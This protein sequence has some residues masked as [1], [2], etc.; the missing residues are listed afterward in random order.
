ME[1]KDK[2]SGKNGRGLDTIGKR[3]LVLTIAI[4]MT[5][6]FCTPTFY[7]ISF[8]DEEEYLETEQPVDEQAVEPAETPDEEVQAEEPQG[9]ASDPVL[10][11]AVTEEPA[12][13]VPADTVDEQEEPA[14]PEE[15]EPAEPAAE[16]PAVEPADEEPQDE[17][18]QDEQPADEEPAGAQPEDVQPAEEPQEPAEEEPA[19][20]PFDDTASANGV[21][22]HVTAEEGVLPEG[23]S[24]NVRKVKG[25]DVS[26]T[27]DEALDTENAKFRAVEFAFEDA[28]GNAV[29]PQDTVTV[30]LTSTAFS[31]DADLSVVDLDKAEEVTDA[32]KEEDNSVTFTADGPMTLALAEEQQPTRGGDAKAGDQPKM[33]T[34]TFDSTTDPNEPQSPDEI[35]VVNGEA[36]G[37]QLP[38]VPE[39][40][41]YVTYWVIQGTD[42]VV[43]ADTVVTKPFTAVVKQGNKITYTV[44]FVQEDGTTSTKTTDIDSGFAIRE[45]PEVTP[46]ANSVGKWVYPNTTNEFTVGTVISEDLTVNAYYE[47]DI[48]TVS[49]MVDDAE[50]SQMTTAKGASIILPTD[51]VKAGTTFKGWYTEPNGEGTRYTD[52]EGEEGETTVTSDLTLYAYFEG[53]VT[54]KFLVKDDNGNIITEKSQYFIDLTVGDEITTLPDDPFIEGK[55]FDHWEHETTHATVDVGTVVTKSFNAV[56]VFKEIDTYEL[57]VYYYY[58]NGDNEV[59]IQTQVYELIDSDFTGEEETYT[60]TAPGFTIAS[61]IPDKPTYYPSRPT[62]TVKKSDFT[63]ENGKYV[64]LENDE[65][66]KADGKY[67]VGHYL[68]NLSGEGYSLIGEFEP[69]EGVKNTEVTP[70]INSYPYADFERRDENVLIED[71][72]DQILSVYYTR[73]DFTLSYNVDGGDYIEAVTAPYGT[74]IPLPTTATRKGYTFEGWY[75][76]TEAVSG[77]FTLEENTTLDAHWTPADVNYKIVYMLENADDDGYS[78][79][80]DVT[81]QEATGTTL[82]LTKAQADSYAPSDLDLQNFT[83]KESTTEK[84]K[85][86]GSSVIVVKYS[87]NVYTLNWNG[88]RYH[89]TVDRWGNVSWNWDN[90]S[91]SG[92]V[93]A[94]Y[95]ASITEA[96]ISTFNTP[97]PDYAWALTQQNDDKIMAIDTMPGR[98]EKWGTS[99]TTLTFPNNV[100][101]VYAFDFSTTKM[102]TLNYWL[103]NYTGEGV[104]T[105]TRDGKTYGLYKDVT[106][107][108]NYLYDNADFYYI[109]G[110]D[111][112]GYE[113]QY[114]RVSYR[115]GSRDYTDADLLSV[116]TDQSTLTTLERN[117]KTISEY[118]VSYSGNTYYIKYNDEWYKLDDDGRYVYNASR[119]YGIDIDDSYILGN[120]TPDGNLILNFYYTAKTHDLTFYNYDGTLISTQKVKLNADISGYLEDNIPENPK[121]G[122]V[123]IDGTEWLGWFTD[124]EHTE[125]YTVEEGTTPKMPAGL[126]LY[127]NFSFPERTVTF[128]SQG[129]SAV[130]SQ[131][132]EYGFYASVPTDPTRANYTFQGWFTAADETGAPYDWNSPVKNDITLYAHWTQKTISYIVHYYEQGTTNSVLPDKEVSDPSFREGQEI[133]ENAPTVAGH[134]ADN[135]SVTKALSFNEEENVIIFYY[136]TIPDEIEYTVNYVLKSNPSIKVAEPKTITVP[137]STTTVLEKAVAADAAYIA[138]QTS[139]ADIIGKNYKPTET[140]K[141]LQLAK[142][143]NVITFEYI[144]YTT[145]KITV[146]YLDMDG[147]SIH[148]ADTSYVE[149]GDTFTV[150]NKAPDGFVYHHAYLGNTS[151]AP[152]PV[153]QITGDEGDL[154]INIYYQKKLIILAENKSKTYDGIPLTSSFVPSD[155]KVTG[156]DRGDTLSSVSFDGSQTDAGTS[157][158]TPKSAVITLGTTGEL[159]QHYLCS[160]LAHC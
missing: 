148:A 12:D 61:Q 1:K 119:I 109:D 21:T 118:V 49:F 141:E 68:K 95:G 22:V 2:K 44:T 43:D 34:V 20:V 38:Q 137:G 6:Q 140:T 72:P 122:G 69:K 70:E 114:M 78:F 56:A 9:E 42:T 151:T 16:E 66:K 99:E 159:L 152:E 82:T 150:Q 55:E 73:K 98:G 124:A 17:P 36:I 96:W 74:Q 94:K 3:I 84:I 71:D 110:Y 15:V 130:E 39:I 86:D 92:S 155:Y 149:K 135:A 75:N 145:T 62:I 139:D 154:V 103:E 131:T 59:E 53:Q 4:L 51:P 146:N 101:T 85:A 10:D 93:T 45:L 127:G 102:Q 63:L 126:V 35:E 123:T 77:T 26:S 37:S 142:D 25:Y 120:S 32:T 121:D 100:Q 156:L 138:G 13:E 33:I 57:T 14:A 87:R 134:V 132:D 54:V 105:T 104:E 5:F 67:K 108:F 83:F 64:R 112:D 158:T 129:G 76:G 65:F 58:M 128:D 88:A 18:V 81:K 8:A 133:T 47:Q 27:V 50:Y 23:A 31:A 41:G 113:S 79:L 11:E 115:Y 90:V 28:E 46:K 29:D 144:P 116:V 147:N 143:N 52:K 91:G 80:K 7:G 153:Y 160:R 48:F 24:L 107:R 89:R 97:Y 30:N 125:P 111:K 136:Y 40:P 60:V 157:T 117:K 19:E 106:G